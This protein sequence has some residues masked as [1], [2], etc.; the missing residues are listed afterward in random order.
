MSIAKVT[1]TGVNIL[2]ANDLTS[3]VSAVGA[4]GTLN[5]TASVSS[6]GLAPNA[7]S[8]SFIVNN[9]SLEDEG[10]IVCKVTT[11]H[12][13]VPDN[14]GQVSFSKGEAK[15]ASQYLWSFLSSA[16]ANQGYFLISAAEALGGKLNASDTQSTLLGMTTIGKA[17]FVEVCIWWKGTEWGVLIDGATFQ[18]GTRANFAD[19]FHTI[20]IG[21][22]FNGTSSALTNG[23]IKDLVI[24]N[25]SPR[26]QQRFNKVSL[27]IFGDSFTENFAS[28]GGTPRYDIRGDA[29]IHGLSYGWKFNRLNFDGN[30]G[31][32]VGDTTSSDLSNE[33]DDFVLL[34]NDVAV[35]MAGN[36]D[37]TTSTARPTTEANY[38]DF[39]ERIMGETAVGGIK[40]TNCRMVVIITAGSLTNNAAIDNA[41]NQAGLLEVNA[42][43]NS[44]P[45]WWDATYPARTG[46]VR[47][48]D[49][50][51]LLGGDS[52][53]NENYQGYFNSIGNIADGGSA[54]P[55]AQ[56]DR[57]PSA[58]GFYTVMKAIIKSL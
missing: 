52:S 28:L 58:L 33:I 6:A 25:V 46:L 38:K 13:G 27:G 53:T 41:L 35:I 44:L 10:Q 29:L 42:I 39:I 22:A 55:T 34:Q 7:G 56:N 50:H 8:M 26:I 18:T 36:N 3:V 48:I 14:T 47:V 49:L 21:S 4:N 54:T 45:A 2:L 24:S 11:E 57:H 1:D 9:A 16:P 51:S 23:T 5:G 37:A 19:V 40:Y 32:T 15:S 31:F 20:N 12:F 30:P 43:I 17:E